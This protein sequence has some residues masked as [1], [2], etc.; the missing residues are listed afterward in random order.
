MTEGAT[1]DDFDDDMDDDL[2]D[3]ADDEMAAISKALG[4]SANKGSN[5]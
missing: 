2:F 1:S 5:E 4:D 3:L